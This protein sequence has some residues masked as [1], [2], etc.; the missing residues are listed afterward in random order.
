MVSFKEVRAAVDSAE[1]ISE[2]ERRSYETQ[3][4]DLNAALKAERDRFDAHMLGKAPAE[5]VAT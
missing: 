5:G 2:A 4:A 3:I 1:A